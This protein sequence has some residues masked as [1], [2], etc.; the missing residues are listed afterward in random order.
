MAVVAGGAALAGLVA[1]HHDEPRLWDGLTAGSG[2]AA[3]IVSGV[4]GLAT[5]FLV[6]RARY[7]WARLSAATAV[8]AI[9]AG[10]GLAQRP[11]LLP[12][13][14]IE[15]AAAG[16]STLIA[17]IVALT[18]GAV[19]LVPA[20]GLLFTLVLR[21]RFDQE[22][23][24]AASAPRAATRKLPLLPVALGCLGLGTLLA[25]PLDSAWGRILGIPLLFG[26]LVAGFLWLAGE[27][28]S[29]DGGE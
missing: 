2:L 27:A 7:G 15:Q 12:G 10:W 6:A 23:P 22:R 3:V 21:G 5:V 1:V 17:L 20:L 8:V 29:A 28:V 26:F 16:R 19:V 24:V 18:I 4:G 13:L 11:Q 9:V 14:T 25:V